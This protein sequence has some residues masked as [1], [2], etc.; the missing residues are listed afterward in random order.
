M[1]IKSSR[2]GQSV[3]G[4]NSINY[5]N[6]NRKSAAIQSFEI[7]YSKSCVSLLI[8]NQTIEAAGL[9]QR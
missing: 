9:R 5:D 2:G 7:R 6:Y 4:M 3:E 8:T 1:N